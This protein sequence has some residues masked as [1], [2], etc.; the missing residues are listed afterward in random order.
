VKKTGEKLAAKIYRK[1]EIENNK[2]NEL[3]GR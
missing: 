2:N 1:L 3:N